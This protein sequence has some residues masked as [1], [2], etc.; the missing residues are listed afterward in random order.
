[1]RCDDC[2]DGEIDPAECCDPLVAEHLEY[3]DGY[4]AELRRM[5]RACDQVR[6]AL[7]GNDRDVLAGAIEELIRSDHDRRACGGVIDGLIDDFG[8]VEQRRLRAI[9]P[10]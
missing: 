9:R 3:L 1:M 7:T 4:V 5:V 6:A 8:D 2:R 10:W